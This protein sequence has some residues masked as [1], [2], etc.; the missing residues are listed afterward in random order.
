MAKS[1]RSPLEKFMAES[2]KMAKRRDADKGFSFDEKITIDFLVG[3]Y[4]GQRGLCIHTGEEMTLE[5]GLVGKDENGKGG[6]P[7]F[8][9][10]TIDRIDNTR[11]YSTD[12]IMMACDGI[13]RMRGNMSL[14]RFRA[15]CKKVG[16]SAE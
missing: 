11:G 9:L 8:T 3:L 13:N 5:R 14:K 7:C 6:I 16:L 12:N 1:T 10:C 2:I 4:R 15:L